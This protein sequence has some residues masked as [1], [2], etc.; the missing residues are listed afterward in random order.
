MIIKR[1]IMK[2]KRKRIKETK[3]RLK[4]LNQGNMMPMLSETGI[5]CIEVVNRKM[6]RLRTKANS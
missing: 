2:M 5:G 3:I 4:I 6:V 1:K